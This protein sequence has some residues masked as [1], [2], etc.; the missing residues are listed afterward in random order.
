MRVEVGKMGSELGSEQQ[1]QRRR[2]G[3]K[4]QSSQ[5]PN[6]SPSPERSALCS[7]LSDFLAEPKGKADSWG[8]GLALLKDS[9]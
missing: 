6:P 9:V 5:V 3:R 8:E 2:E 1:S 7:D 4:S